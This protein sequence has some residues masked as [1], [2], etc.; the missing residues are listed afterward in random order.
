MSL[1]KQYVRSYPMQS[2]LLLYNIGIFSFLKVLVSPFGGSLSASH[3]DLLAKMS[4]FTGFD[5]D[6]IQD[7]ILNSPYRWLIISLIL[8]IIVSF[9][10]RIIKMLIALFV[11]VIGLVLVY[12]YAKMKGYL[13]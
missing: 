10:G 7:F 8:T 3:S 12:V 6:K 5:M 9:V 4:R 2:F 11:I 1:I 13:G